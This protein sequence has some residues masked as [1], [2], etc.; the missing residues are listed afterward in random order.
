MNKKLKP[1]IFVQGKYGYNAQ[2]TTQ[3][4]MLLKAL[5]ITQDPKKL[6][7]LMIDFDSLKVGGEVWHSQRG[8]YEKI[9]SL[10]NLKTYQIRLSIALDDTF[11]KT[12][13]SHENHKLPTIWKSNPF[14]LISEYPKEMMVSD[15]GDDWH[16]RIVIN[17]FES[18]FVAKSHYGYNFK[19]WKY[20][21]EIEPEQKKK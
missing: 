9:E 10:D 5:T 17:I 6:R 3:Q 16:D 2:N 7:D 14:D 13:L 11:T 19:L 21:K 8:Q 15:D 4:I 20:A 1:V 18:A 12:G